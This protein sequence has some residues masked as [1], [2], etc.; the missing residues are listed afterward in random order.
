[1]RG[2]W[3]AV[4]LVG[5]ACASGTLAPEGQRRRT[6]RGRRAMR[7]RT[8]TAAGGAS[9]ASNPVAG[10]GAGAG[11][12][13]RTGAGRDDVGADGAR[14]RRVRAADHAQRQAA[15]AAGRGGPALPSLRERGIGSAVARDDVPRRRA[16]A[17]RTGLGTV[18]LIATDGWREVTEIVS[19]IGRLDAAAFS[20][21]S[22]QLAVMSA[23]AGAITRVGRARRGAAAHA[24]GTAGS[25]HRSGRVGARVFVERT[26][27]GDVAGDDHRPRERRIDPVDAVGPQPHAASSLHAGCESAGAVRRRVGAR[28][29]LHRGRRDV[30][31]RGVVPDRQLA[32]H[33]AHRGV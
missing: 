2:S 28:A 8:T 26:P 31:Q 20:P 10:D 29:P 17:A 16:L 3:L 19:P 13:S 1:M 15:T 6:P 12:G 14:Q 9:A 27:A 18:R 23:E 5:V 21:D 30:V 24:G 11:T 32:A 25:N 7:C 33:G 22:T 4:G